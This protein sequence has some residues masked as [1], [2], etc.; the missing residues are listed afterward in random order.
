MKRLFGI[1]NILFIVGVAVG[2][3]FYYRN[4]GLLLKGITSSF[5]ALLGI[6]NL[7]YSFISKSR[8]RFPL[9]IALGLLLSATGDI[10]IGINF[11]AGA[12]IFA[13]G[14]IAYFAA[15]CFKSRFSVKDLVPSGVIF[16]VASAFILLYD[17]L[18][19]GGLI[20]QAVCII[21]ALIISLMCGK[22]IAMYMALREKAAALAALGSVLFLIS[23]LMLLIYCFGGGAE[24]VNTVC[25]LTYFPAQCLI[26]L[27]SFASTAKNQ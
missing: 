15:Y 11:I 6:I 8:A 2:C 14:H 18:E 27:S 17:A 13:L 19:F 24:A 26:A 3:F 5:F 1:L 23:D 9:L 21:Y 22:A 10:V 4:G 16:A 12:L 20:M 25:M 7:L